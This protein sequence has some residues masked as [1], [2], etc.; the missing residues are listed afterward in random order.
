MYSAWPPCISDPVPLRERG[1]TSGGPGGTIRSVRRW[2]GS[3]L[4]RRDRLYCGWPHPKPQRQSRPPARGRVLEETVLED[5]LAFG[6]HRYSKCHSHASL[7][8]LHLVQPEAEE[9]L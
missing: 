3:M 2:T 7:P 5:V 1:R 4:T 9:H 8:A 6:A